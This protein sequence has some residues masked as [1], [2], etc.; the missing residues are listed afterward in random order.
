MTI[1]Q[2][3]K[4]VQNTAD[5]FRGNLVQRPG[6]DFLRYISARFHDLLNDLLNK[7]LNKKATSQQPKMTE[8][9]KSKTSHK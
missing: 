5:N 2:V 9:E 7:E 1:E 3:E 4:F 6:K 8:N